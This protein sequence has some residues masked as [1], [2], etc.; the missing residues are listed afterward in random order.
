MEE[1]FYKDGLKFSCQRCSACCRFDPGF[2]NLSEQD[3]A[4]LQTWSGLDRETVITTWCRWV[5]RGDGEEYL[6]LKEKA[7]FDCILW[8]N[9]CIAYESRPIQCSS[10]P[11]WASL[12]SDEDWWEA[13]AR[14]C[15]GINKGALHTREEIEDHLTRRRAQPY[16]HRKV[17]R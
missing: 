12:V 1:P 4:A 8:D 7:D 16:I 9:G 3:L 13:N 6:C 15:P 14:D 5:N 17:K 2:V 11:F 10:Y